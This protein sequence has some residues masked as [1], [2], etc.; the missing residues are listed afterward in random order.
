MVDKSAKLQELPE[1]RFESI[2]LGATLLAR[3][4][5][6]REVLFESL[7]IVEDTN[8]QRSAARSGCR[9]YSADRFNFVRVRTRLSSSHS[10]Q[11]PD[12]EFMKR[13]RDHT[14]GLDLGRVM[15]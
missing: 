15:V 9:I 4:D 11:T 7:S 14:P 5:V 8:F 10:N 12:A 2:V 3:T 6:A 13:C 1:H